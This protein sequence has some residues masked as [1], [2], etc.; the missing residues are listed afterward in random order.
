VTRLICAFEVDRDGERAARLKMKWVPDGAWIELH[1]TETWRNES[2]NDRDFRVWAKLSAS[3]A[4]AL[5]STELTMVR[6]GTNEYVVRPNPKKVSH[7]D[8]VTTFDG[9]DDLPSQGHIRVENAR[10]K[11]EVKLLLKLDEDEIAVPARGYV[12]AVMT[13]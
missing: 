10:V 5:T 8:L 6:S 13:G 1:Y 4:P 7:D 2:K 3:D 12:D 11:L 9:P